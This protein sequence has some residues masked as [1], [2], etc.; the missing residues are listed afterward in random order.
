MIYIVILTLFLSLV[1]VSLL[2]LALKK[3][4]EQ[5]YE[6]IER[7]REERIDLYNRL[8]SRNLTDYAQNTGDGAAR[9]HVQSSKNFLKD[10][11]KEALHR[12]GEESGFP[13]GDY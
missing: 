13:G 10:A 3:E 11:T 7:E 9:P 4:R 6:L 12:M 2:T 5:I 8:M 1:Y